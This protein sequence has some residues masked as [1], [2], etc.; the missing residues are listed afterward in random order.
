[1]DYSA[2][3]DSDYNWFEDHVTELYDLYGEAY[4]V[5]QQKKVLG[6]YASYAEAVHETEKTEPLGS[7]IV[8]LC[9]PTKESLIEYVF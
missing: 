4:V 2:Q 1:M 8:Q 7:F 6:A 9:G 3:R 5:I